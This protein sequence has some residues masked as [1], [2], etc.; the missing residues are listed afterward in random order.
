[1]KDIKAV[2]EELKKHFLNRVLDIREIPLQ[3]TVIQIAPADIRKI[4]IWLLEN[5]NF[6]HLSTI[7][8]VDNGEQI[9][10]FYHFWDGRGLSLCIELPRE[11]PS[12]AT[13]SDMIPGATFYERE[14]FEMLGVK[15]DNLEDT[16]RL[17]MADDW[18]G[19]HFQLRAEEKSIKK[20]NT[21]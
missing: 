3:E 17:L 7:T 12:V 21:R 20:E 9:E 13:I 1:M 2:I 18:D 5:A 6:Y 14:V 4:T 15:F 16:R 10:L 19:Q 11:N 8:G